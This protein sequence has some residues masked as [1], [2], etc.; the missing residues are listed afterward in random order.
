MARKK[1]PEQAGNTEGWLNTYAD[2]VTLLLCFFV[3][4]YTASTP[5]EAKM[6]WVLQ[7]FAAIKGD[8]INPVNVDPIDSHKSDGDGNA[9]EF[10]NDDGGDI[11]G[12]PG[13]MP[14]TFDDMFNWVSEAIELNDLRDSVSIDTSYPGRMTIRFNDDI[15]FAADSAVL[16]QSGKDALR[17]L[18]PGIRE[19]NPYIL[20]ASIEGHT[21]P[22]ANGGLRNVNDSALSAAR[23]VEVQYFLNYELPAPM[24]SVEK[25][26][27]KGAGPW[28]PYYFPLTDEA[29]NAKN[30][31]VEL[32][33]SR[34][35]Y[36]ESA[37]RV[38]LDILKYD[39]H[40]GINPGSTI[41]TRIPQ[42]KDLNSYAQIQTTIFEKYG[43]KED[44][45][46]TSG[47]ETGPTAPGNRGIPIDTPGNT[48][49]SNDSG[50]A[51]NVNE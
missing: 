38:L 35:N 16:L 20:E 25:Y 27:V 13:E 32:V 42:P 4:M 31:R 40:I 39:Y 28:E 34:N 36:E 12:I 26:R 48:D 10:P 14:M 49:N 19:F 47:K 8:V 9:P 44:S 46:N 37:T 45:L 21:A 2:M 24:L 5:D 29:A 15:M 11:N 1:Q 43:V 22:N 3:M 18:A 17:K 33:L 50:N 23:A 51:G 41:D 7:S 6:Q 30:R